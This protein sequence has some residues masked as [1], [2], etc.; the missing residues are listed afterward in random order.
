MAL[1]QVAAGDRILAADINQY[2]NWIKGVTGSGETATLIYNAAG[3]LILQPSS[4]PAA[5]TELFQIKNAAGTV[6]AALS[7]DGRVYSG[8]GLVGTPGLTFESDKDTGFY[9]IGADNLGIT[10]GGAKQVDVAASLTSITGS[11]AVGTTPSTT[12]GIR[13]PNGSAGYLKARNAANSADNLLI[14]YGTDNIVYVGQGGNTVQ[15]DGGVVSIGTNP[16]TAGVIRLPNGD[17][18]LINFRNAANSANIEGLK[19][20][21]DNIMGLYDSRQTATALIR[22]KLADGTGHVGAGDP[23]WVAV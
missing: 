19:L 10:V 6:Q 1:Y 11:V 15:F 23:V 16:A 17:S 22:T 12:G 18:G 3:A 9:R 14:G 20:R 2:F 7:S 5:G 21:T 4:N 8:N 13:V